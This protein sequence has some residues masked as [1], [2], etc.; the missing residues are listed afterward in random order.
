[1]ARAGI[2]YPLLLTGG[3]ILSVILARRSPNGA[4]IA[5]VLYSAVALSLSHATVWVHIGNAERVTYEMF[6][7]LAIL[8]VSVPADAQAVRRAVLMFW[9]GAAAYVFFASPAAGA[10]REAVLG[11]GLG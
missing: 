9:A 11:L 6:V 2:W 7:M 10:A 8:S 5:A 1:M 3:A 4:G